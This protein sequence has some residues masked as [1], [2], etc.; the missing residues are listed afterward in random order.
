MN[1][2]MMDTGSF[3]V[4][5]AALMGGDVCGIRVVGLFLSSAVVGKTWQ[6]D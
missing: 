6:Q 5:I 2:A 1:G 3:A 4:L